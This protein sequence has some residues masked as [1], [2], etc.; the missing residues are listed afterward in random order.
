ME[1]KK[2]EEAY[3]RRNNYKKTNHF[4][5]SILIKVKC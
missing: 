3:H 5:I 4:K 2:K 1:T